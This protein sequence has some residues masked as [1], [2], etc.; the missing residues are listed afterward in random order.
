VPTLRNLDKR[1]IDGTPKACMHN[2]VFKSLE[3]VVHF[4]NTREV[5]PGC[6]AVKAPKFGENCWPVP[7]VTA[8]VNRIEL[9][10]L[11]MNNEEG[12]RGPCPERGRRLSRATRREEVGRTGGRARNAASAVAPLRI[13]SVTCAA[14]QPN[15]SM[16]RAPNPRNMS[17]AGSL[18][19]FG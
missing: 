3:D 8:N 18:M 17:G 7:E 1:G 10:D 6:S 14:T 15:Q 12:S 19:R 11:R 16:T 2:G 5:L 13:H 4:H 9:G